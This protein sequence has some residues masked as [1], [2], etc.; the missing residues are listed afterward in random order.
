MDGSKILINNFVMK[1][2]S[3]AN[4]I[5]GKT[6]YLSDFGTNTSTDFICKWTTDI[7]KSKELFCDGLLAPHLKM[8]DEIININKNTPFYKKR[9]KWVDV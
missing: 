6:Y 2:L 3:L 5:N 8:L 9:Y 1:I 4:Q 7:K